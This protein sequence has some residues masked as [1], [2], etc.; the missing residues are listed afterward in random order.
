MKSSLLVFL[1]LTLVLP[2]CEKK[3]EPVPVGQMTEY[4][5]PGFG[6]KVKYPA[7]WINLGTT[8][9]AVFAKSQD[10]L[11]K[12]LDPTTGEEGAQVI[13]EAIPFSGKTPTDIIQGVK[14][15]MKQMT[16]QIGPDSQVTVAGKPATRFPYTIQATTKTN[17][18]GYQIFVP[19]DTVLFRL[20]FEG[21]GD[22]FAAHREVFD[23]VQASFQ[24]P[25]YV[26]KKSTVW[27]AS[28]NLE[29][30]SSPFFTLRYPENLNPVDVKKG[31][32]DDFAMEMRADRLD[33]SIHIDVFGA[34]KL[35]VEKVWD[36]NKAA[37]HARSNGK[38]TIDGQP[39]IYADYAP[40]K[41]ISSRVYFTVK[42]DKVIR[43]T[44]NYYTPQKDAYWPVFENMVKSITLK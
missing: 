33:C 31:P 30:F 19:G 42:N 21:Y 8:G 32:K 43:I 37:Y 9:K 17:I 1:V 5:D 10:V 3:I 20:D 23:A 11:N 28:G 39:T 12:F 4:R 24:L 44:I 25:A 15:D 22:Q 36:Q 6:F 13:V 27:Q 29:T 2:G 38:T 34:Q 40:R 41:D 14:N 18:Y 35:T 7:Q 16:A 26:P